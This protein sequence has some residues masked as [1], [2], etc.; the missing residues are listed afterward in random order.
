MAV[1]HIQQIR[2]QIGEEQFRAWLAED[3]GKQA[4]E[5]IA[6]LDQGKHERANR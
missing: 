4:R 6:A 1:H 5:I 3:F 2:E